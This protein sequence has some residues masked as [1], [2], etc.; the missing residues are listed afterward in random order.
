MRSPVANYELRRLEG[1]ASDIDSHAV[2]LVELSNTMNAT[3]R[4]LTAIG[5]SSVHKSKGTDKLAESATAA[6]A[7]LSAAAIRYEETGTALK[8]YAEALDAAQSWIHPR[9]DDIENAERNYQLALDTKN[10]A[11]NTVDGFLGATNLQPEQ[12][13]RASCRE[14]VF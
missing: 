2:G 10:A 8:K 4:E 12:I 9:I 7:D 5:D 14:R 13:G 1:N 11:K 3:V 6:A